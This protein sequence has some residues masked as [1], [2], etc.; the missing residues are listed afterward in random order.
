[1][2]GIMANISEG[3]VIR[4]ICYLDP[5]VE[6]EYDIKGRAEGEKGKAGFALPSPL[7][8]RG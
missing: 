6:P 3:E 1:M 4:M 7:I 2:D 8:M 5:R